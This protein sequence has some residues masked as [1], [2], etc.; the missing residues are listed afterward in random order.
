[1]G[2]TPDSDRMTPSVCMSGY[3]QRTR[4]PAEPDKATMSRKKAAVEEESADHT[5]L[6]PAS[7]VESEGAAPSQ[8]APQQEEEKVDVDHHQ[9]QPQHHQ[10]QHH[11]QQPPQ[12]HNQQPPA[13]PA[14]GRLSAIQVMVASTGLCDS[15]YERNACMTC[16]CMR[17]LRQTVAGNGMLVTD[18]L[19]PFMGDHVLSLRG[20]GRQVFYFFNQ[21]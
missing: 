4:D 3:V 17:V 9:Q 2:G 8:P 12:H 20:L 5:G 13:D 10:P 1:M 7:S 14:L 19:G 18:L 15:L 16:A 6:A 11:N 21:P